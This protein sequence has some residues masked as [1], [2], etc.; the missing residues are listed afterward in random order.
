M[1]IQNVQNLAATTLADCVAFQDFVGAADSTAALLRIHHD[2]FP[3]PEA[4]KYTREELEDVRPCALIYTPDSQ[5][6]VTEYDATDAHWRTHGII[7]F[8]LYRT[9]P[10]NIADDPGE[11]ATSFREIVSDLI[12]ELQEKGN[13][14]DCLI[15]RKIIANGPFRNDPTKINDEGDEQAY[16]LIVEWGVGV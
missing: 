7:Y 15:V 12:V 6:Y 9:V 16:E 13:E 10:A 11:V 5:G 8:V 1:T 2:A 4:D 3:P 14:A